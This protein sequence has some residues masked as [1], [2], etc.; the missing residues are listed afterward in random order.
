M[1]AQ[2]AEIRSVAIY[3][4]KQ[5]G[6]MGRFLA[7]I[8]A[9]NAALAPHVK[10][11]VFTADLDAMENS[12]LLRMVQERH[13]NAGDQSAPT[14]SCS[15]AVQR[16]QKMQDGDHDA[17]AELQPFTETDNIRCGSDCILGREW[18][19]CKNV[20][21]VTLPAAWATDDVSGHTPFWQYFDVD[22]EKQYKYRYKGNAYVVIGDTKAPGTE[23]GEE[24]IQHYVAQHSDA[25]RSLQRFWARGSKLP[26]S[27]EHLI[28][29][30]DPEEMTPEQ[31][32]Q[33]LA[34]DDFSPSMEEVCAMGHEVFVTRAVQ[35]M[36]SG[37]NKV[38]SLVVPAQWAAA[39]EASEAFPRVL[40]WMRCEAMTEVT[41][42]VFVGNFGLSFTK[43]REL[44]DGQHLT[45]Q[46]YLYI[47]YEVYMVCE[48]LME[49]GEI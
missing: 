28:I 19:I 16:D 41:G 38:M 40:W 3:E 11:V 49:T 30:V 46:A 9:N 42:L 44:G 17:I 35:A 24:K 22:V 48:Y 36:F 13:E 5:C 12:G 4:A 34:S 23:G 10:H 1:S 47:E 45:D 39:F 18:S 2:A 7:K 31:V 37:R 6:D 43:L 29:D 15:V 8:G 32:V 26:E 21:T 14:H 33:L 27:V 25:E 20:R